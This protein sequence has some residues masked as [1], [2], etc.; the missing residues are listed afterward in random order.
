M[1]FIKILLISK[2]LKYTTLQ[3]AEIM[4]LELSDFLSF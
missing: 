4:I 1:P 3:N 2:L